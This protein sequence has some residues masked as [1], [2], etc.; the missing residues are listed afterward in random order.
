VNAADDVRTRQV[1]VLV[2]ALQGRAAEIIGRLSTDVF[3]AR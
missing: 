2:A 3:Q 1:E